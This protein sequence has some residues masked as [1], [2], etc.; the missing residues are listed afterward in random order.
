VAAV[1]PASVFVPSNRALNTA[2]Q[3]STT[4]DAEVVYGVDIAIN[5]TLLVTT[6]GTAFLEYA[7]NSAMSTNLVT[8]SSSTA[9]LGGVLNVQNTQTATLVGRIPAGKY[10]RIRT[11]IVSGTPIFTVRQGQE[12]LL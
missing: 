1:I 4:R 8:V 5:L 11:Q 9:M 7:D 12:V 6:Q 3:I 10:V 2:F